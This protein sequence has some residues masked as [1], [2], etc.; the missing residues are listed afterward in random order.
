[1]S[2]LFGDM[3]QIG[4]VVTDL[5][6]S[7]R[8]WADICSVGPWFWFEKSSYI[9]YKHRGIVYDTLD[10]TVGFANS[11]EIQLELIQQRCKTPSMYREFL[12]K[13]PEGGMQHWSSWPVDYKERYEAALKAG[14]TI[15]MEGDH[16][17]GAFVYFEKADGD[18][19]SVI[20]MAELTPGRKTFFD[21]VR[22]AAAGWDGRDPI[23]KM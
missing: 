18:P 23:R 13:H 10:L 22:D 11:G 20:E 4:F 12:A 6:K 9:V 2:K 16:V 5:Q 15:A 17:R 3:R 19:G 1:M 7:M 8:H 21:M 14:Y